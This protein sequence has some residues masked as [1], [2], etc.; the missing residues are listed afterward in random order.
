MPEKKTGN[1]HIDHAGP[2]TVQ[3]DAWEPFKTMKARKG[4]EHDHDHDEEEEHAHGEEGHGHDH[5][6]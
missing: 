1:P 5:G 3:I 4:H 2:H 6:H